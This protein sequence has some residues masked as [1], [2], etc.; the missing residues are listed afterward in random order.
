M[1]T[2]SE[3]ERDQCI[4]LLIAKIN[5]LEKEVALLKGV[6]PAEEPVRNELPKPVYVTETPVQTSHVHVPPKQNVPY[7]TFE[8]VIG[9]QWIGRIGVVAVILGVAFFLKYSFDNNLIGEAGRVMLGIVSGIF[10][11]GLGEFLHKKKNL[12][13]YGEMLSGGGLAV[14]YLSFYAAFVLFHL[15]PF[16]L[17]MLGFI[18]VTTTGMM[19]AVRYSAYSLSVIAL[20]GG[21]LTPLLLSDGQNQPVE[22]FSYILLLDAGTLLLLRYRLWPSLAV[23]SLFGTA[24]IYGVWHSSFYTQ[25]QQLFSFGVVAVVYL[26]YN[27]YIISAPLLLNQQEP[28]TYSTVIFGSAALFMLAFL[29]QEQF[30]ITWALKFFSIALAGVEIGFAQMA[31][32]RSVSNRVTV[33]SYVAASVVMTVVAT[34]IAMEQRW[35]LSTLAVEMAVLGWC[36]FRL[37]VPQFRWWVYFLGLIVLLLFPGY[38]M[39]QVEP[40]ERFIPVFNS[41]FL[42][43]SVVVA[44]FYTL[45]Y[46]GSQYTKTVTINEQHILGLIFYIIQ[47][48]SLILVSVE[49]HDFF[50]H[51]LPESGSTDYAYQLSLSVFF[52]LYASL[53]TGAGIYKRVRRA[54][55][56]GIALLGATMLKVFFL[57]LSFLQPLYRIVSFIVLGLLLLAVSYGYNRFRDII[58]GEDQT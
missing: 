38:V 8:K 21:F 31:L 7:P 15:I 52:A 37:D 47:A 45:L 2:R 48:L 1:T 40:F 57:D 33:I 25:E 50:Y 41:R 14:L 23:L 19:L 56:T 46:T 51:S 35:L 12:G 49:I 27:L 20:L 39:L 26:C 36:W 30:V 53:L 58:F 10:V 6:I 3:Q 18:G 32:R 11:L 43:C 54:R 16:S 9:T 13:L 5:E 24:L 22:L 28:T 4:D 55:V 29:A 34:Y 17:A 44:S 42:Y